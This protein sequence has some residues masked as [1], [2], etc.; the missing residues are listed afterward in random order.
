MKSITV[1]GAGY[2]G[3]VTA[4]AFADSGNPVEVVEKDLN[5]LQK[6]QN[7]EMPFF[8]SGLIDLLRRHI[9]TGNLSFTNRPVK[10]GVDF[11]FI[12]VGTPSSED[13]ST[14]LSAV[15]A[16]ADEIVSFDYPDDTFVVL[17]STCPPGTTNR[18]KEFFIEKGKNYSVAFNPEFLKQGNAL[19]DALRPERIVIGV[20][21]VRASEA[22]QNLFRP[23][24]KN[25]NPILTMSTITAELV[26]YVANCYLA[27]RISFINEVA[28][29]CER[30]GANV[31]DLRKAVGLDS[32]IGVKYFYPG[33][34]YGGS[35]F[36]KDV[37]SLINFSRKSGYEFKLAV[38]CN[39]VNA[40]QRIVI[41]KK[42]LDYYNQQV[43]GKKFA[44]WGLAFK[45]GTDDV[46]ESVAYYS[47]KELSKMGA[48]FR[49]FDPEAMEKF[50]A[51]FPDLADHVEFCSNQYQAL[52]GTNALLIF[53][54]WNIF[55][56][57]DLTRLKEALADKLI[58][59]GRNILDPV[60]LKAH[61]LRYVGIGINNLGLL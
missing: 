3:L 44:V 57:P 21:D 59:D 41:A 13:G 7:G 4:C 9:R 2:V 23:F 31:E 27:L 54:D 38:T 33:C 15:W 29:I 46:R 22:L 5:K 30:L 8:E 56:D 26:K 45:Q 48:S 14:D 20:E 47:L 49:A 19:E 11:I 28:N 55:K 16:V 6:L 12:C 50:K 37:A 36:P 61:G 51:S 60:V 53:T 58:F 39:E 1:F 42:V 43:E 35:C 17:K 34:G 10:K 24:V 18:L 40:Y 52:E 25:G 32:R